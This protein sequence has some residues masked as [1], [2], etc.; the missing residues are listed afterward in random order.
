M[1]LTDVMNDWII[2]TITIINM[3]EVSQTF[4]RA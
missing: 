1:S 4:L 2:E 3:E